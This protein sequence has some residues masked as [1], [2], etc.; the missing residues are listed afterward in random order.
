MMQRH[1]VEVVLQSEASIAEAKA[2]YKAAVRESESR[3]AA[4]R[5]QVYKWLSAHGVDR[6][7]VDLPDPTE[8]LHFCPRASARPDQDRWSS[9]GWR[10]RRVGALP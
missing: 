7:K 1:Y 3:Q 10:P 2:A 9:G 8:D 4:A 5:D 6:A